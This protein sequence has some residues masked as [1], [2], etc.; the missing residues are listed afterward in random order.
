MF[1]ARLMIAV[2][3]SISGASHAFAADI[4]YEKLG[5]ES[6][7]ERPVI[8][9]AQERERIVKQWS[10]TLAKLDD[11][12]LGDVK[13]KIHDTTRLAALQHD[14]EA[15]LKTYYTQ[16]RPILLNNVKYK[17]KDS[18]ARENQ[19][20]V[21]QLTF[22][23]SYNHKTKKP[24]GGIF[25]YKQNISD[26]FFSREMVE[27]GLLV[28][29]PELEQSQWV[30]DALKMEGELRGFQRLN[31]AYMDGL[32]FVSTKVAGTEKSSVSVN[33]EHVKTSVQSWS[34]HKRE[35][36][37]RKFVR[38][39]Q[40]LN[41]NDKSDDYKAKLNQLLDMYEYTVKSILV[42][43]VSLHRTDIGA[44]ANL[45]D[46]IGLFYS[47]SAKN[48]RGKPISDQLPTAMQSDEVVQNA[49]VM[50]AELETL[51]EEH[52]VYLKNENGFLY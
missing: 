17:R 42:D 3:L 26:S 29:N 21:A 5:L 8:A 45:G 37:V 24:I 9:D 41:F 35:K 39:M 22:P 44:R 13:N 27:A 33:P 18:A 40:K 19:A 52:K 46:L 47:S 43:N 30:Q 48:R 51:L 14:V 10:K 6:K 11:R 4:V 23:T 49:L 34:D 36:V 50:E 38:I 15:I 1:L 7:Q 31:L 28:N 32:K 12:G 20:N 25:N 16:V 2:L